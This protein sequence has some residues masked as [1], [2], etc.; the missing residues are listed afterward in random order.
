MQPF[1]PFSIDDFAQGRFGAHGRVEITGGVDLG[2]S[3]LEGPFNVEAIRA[4]NLARLVYL[5]QYPP[6]R[7][8]AILGRCRQSMLT[9]PEGIEAHRE[10]LRE[11]FVDNVRPPV[12]VAWVAQGDVEGFELMASFYQANFES[13]GVPMRCFR[14]EAEARAWIASL[15]EPLARR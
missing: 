11:S 4:S 9:S 6:Q 7:A 8:W 2:V 1:M 3:L 15:L 5:R 12:A 14:E 13:I 10:G